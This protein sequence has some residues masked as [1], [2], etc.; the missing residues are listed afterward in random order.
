M[1]SAWRVTWPS[2]RAARRGRGWDQANFEQ[3]RAEAVASGLIAGHEVDQVLAL[4]DD[5]TFIASFT[6]MMTAWG[7][8][9]AETRM[10][11]DET[12]GA[13]AEES[14]SASSAGMG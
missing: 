9:A 7:H 11:P 4:L 8:Q 3:I 1:R 10:D 14:V 12:E 5:P 2:G 6:V 13:T